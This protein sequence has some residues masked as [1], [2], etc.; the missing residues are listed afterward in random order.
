MWVDHHRRHIVVVCCLSSLKTLLQVGRNG[1]EAGVICTGG[2][3][4]LP[5]Y[6]ISVVRRH[7]KTPLVIWNLK[8][9]IERLKRKNP[10]A[11]L[12]EDLT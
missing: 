8:M 1:A 7:L 4:K 10:W 3:E 12:V 9:V 5:L 6:T 2:W 11:N